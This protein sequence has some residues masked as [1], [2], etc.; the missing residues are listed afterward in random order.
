[1]ATVNFN[2]PKKKFKAAI[3]WVTIDGINFTSIEGE[4]TIN[5]VN[6]HYILNNDLQFIR[7]EAAIKY[8]ND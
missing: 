2:A 7:L 8:L 3:R 5:K 1:M 6:D 4:H